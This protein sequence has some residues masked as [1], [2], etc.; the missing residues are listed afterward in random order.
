MVLL[1]Q[2][3]SFAQIALILGAVALTAWAFAPWRSS[4]G[5]ARLN[6][7][8]ALVT[9]AVVGIA[10]FV[11]MGWLLGFGCFDASPDSG[12]TTAFGLAQAAAGLLAAATS[13]IGY[14]VFSRLQ[15]RSSIAGSFLGPI[16]VVAL[17]VGVGLL[18]QNVTYAA[19][20]EQDGQTADQMAAR[21]T[22]LHPT[23]AMVHVTMSASGTVVDSVRLRVT[24]HVDHEIRLD[25]GAKNPN[26][27]FEFAATGGMRIDGTGG[28]SS[29]SPLLPATDTMY[30]LTFVGGAVAAGPTGQRVAS[31]FVSP[32]PGTWRMRISVLDDTGVEYQVET[33]VVISAAA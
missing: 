26:P 22:S 24:L 20:L 15:R 31:T 16:V 18:F 19:Q 32:T 14:A 5:R 27:R 8:V 33:D 7:R 10:A 9:G 30:D 25:V 23:V 12:C 11:A 17:V 2:L 29:G 6:I 28:A 3:I 1:A 21:S 4:A 13:F